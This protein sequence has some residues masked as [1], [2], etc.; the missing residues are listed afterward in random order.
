MHIYIYILYYLHTKLYFFVLFLTFGN[1]I[2]NLNLDLIL[3]RIKN[4]KNKN[5]DPKI[6]IFV[7]FFFTISILHKSE[8]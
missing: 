7:Y 5:N 1:L 2:N 4:K 8:K 6:V 3:V